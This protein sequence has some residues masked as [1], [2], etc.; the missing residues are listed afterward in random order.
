M[1]AYCDILNQVLAAEKDGWQENRTGIPTIRLPGAIFKHNMAEGYP[2]LT[3]KRVPFRL[4]ATELE[5]FIKGT[6]DKQWLIDR[7]NHIW[8]EWANPTK[9]PYGTDEESK[10]RMKTE[11]DLGPVYGYQWRHFNG[12]YSGA[13]DEP[14]HNNDGGVDQMIS[15]VSKLHSDPS[16]RRMIVSAWN[17]SQLHMMALPPCHVLH[18]VTVTNGRLTW[19]QRS[20]DMFLGVPFNIASYALLLH[21][22]A[23][24][25]GFKEGILTGFFMDVHIYRNHLEQVHKLLAREPR[26]LPTISTGNWNGIFNWSADDTVLSG[27]EPYPTIKAEVAV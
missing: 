11:S 4:I 6:T 17:P 10:E 19:Y 25:G 1:K 12:N 16:D 3:T 24:E 5:F 27:Y 21:L 8:D 18:Q 23:K 9:A 20:C 13:G 22:Y 26:E 15:L 14:S 7:D 2:L